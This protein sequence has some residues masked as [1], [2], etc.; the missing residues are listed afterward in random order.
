MEKSITLIESI[1]NAGGISE[2]I[3]F[4]RIGR[5]KTPAKLVRELRPGDRFVIPSTK[6][7]FSLISSC[8]LSNQYLSI[9]ASN[10]AE[11][12]K[13]RFRRDKIVGIIKK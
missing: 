10:G 8:K 13:F 1:L 5:N 11:T 7:E 12:L 3:R 6:E 4:V 2:G 9:K